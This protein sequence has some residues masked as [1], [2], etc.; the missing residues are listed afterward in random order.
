M[1]NFFC[2]VTEKKSEND[3]N[4]SISN[5]FVA[6]KIFKFFM[7]SSIYFKTSCMDFNHFLN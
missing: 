6:V 1:K 5:K 7:L 4:T 2:S 3:C